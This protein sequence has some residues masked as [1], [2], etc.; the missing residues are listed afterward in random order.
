MDLSWEFS[1]KLDGEHKLLHEPV[2]RR[3]RKTI[4][5]SSACVTQ[6]SFSGKNWIDL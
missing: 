2:G 3:F 1:K 6:N 5:Q 4:Q